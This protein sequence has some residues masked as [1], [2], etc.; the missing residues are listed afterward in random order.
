MAAVVV[1]RRVRA[2][3]PA[4]AEVLRVLGRV[5]GRVAS[6]NLAPAQIC[7]RGHRDSTSAIVRVAGF[8]ASWPCSLLSWR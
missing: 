1:A 2:A 8:W 3:L 7:I 6:C 5:S 4:T